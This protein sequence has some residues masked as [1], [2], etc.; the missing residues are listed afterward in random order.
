M[1][2]REN[3]GVRRIERLRKHDL[4]VPCAHASKE[5]AFNNRL[6]SCGAMIPHHP[7]HPC[8]NC[9][10]RQLNSFA[11]QPG[12]EAEILTGSVAI[13]DATSG[14]VVA[15]Q[16]DA[17][18]S[19][20]NRMAAELRHVRFD[21]PRHSSDKPHNE[22]RLSGIVVSHRTFGYTAP[23]PLRRRY[24]CARAMFDNEFPDA[25]DLISEFCREAEHALR[26]QAP[27]VADETMRHAQAVPVAWRIAG[28]PWTSGIINN[29]AALPYHRDSG[30]IVGSW[31]AM[32]G[33]RR[34][35]EGGLLHLVDY[36]VWLTIPNG[37]I[38]IFDGQSCLHGVTPMRQTG[39]NAYR[40]TLVTYAKAGMRKCC[41]NPADEAK[42]AAMAATAAAESRGKK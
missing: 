11:P 21:G 16:V 24:G 3:L 25:R 29:T 33:C 14:D 6:S 5:D 12:P 19:L 20:A 38:T 41:A 15:V 36:D 39:A 4:L 31:S 2:V 42:R 23:V 34:N 27:A 13:V 22:G 1:S 7:K 17:Y 30:N 40:Y 28:T 18:A 35:V 9:G 8:P 37:S 10:M 32:L 26:M